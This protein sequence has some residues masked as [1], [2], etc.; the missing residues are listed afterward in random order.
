MYARLKPLV[1][2]SDILDTLTVEIRLATH[3]TTVT[4]KY[5]C[6]KQLTKQATRVSNMTYTI[7][8]STLKDN[9]S[10]FLQSNHLAA[11]LSVGAVDSRIISLSVR[12]IHSGYRLLTNL[13]YTFSD[14]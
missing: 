11:S 5:A 13:S 10:G 7:N 2:N 3:Q 12:L 8:F 6:F 14:A 9:L 1:H 4:V